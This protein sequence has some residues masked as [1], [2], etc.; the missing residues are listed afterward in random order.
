MSSSIMIG[1]HNNIARTATG[2]RCPLKCKAV[3]VEEAMSLAAIM[4]VT[5]ITETLPEEKA[6]PRIGTLR[7][8]AT[9][10]H[11]IKWFTTGKECGKP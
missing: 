8:P 2:V 10:F 6:I 9:E 4:E 7:V 1:V 11:P 5:A 3:E